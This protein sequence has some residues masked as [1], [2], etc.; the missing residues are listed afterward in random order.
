VLDML[1]P[2]SVI[3]S[4]ALGGGQVNE[5][6][7]SMATPHVAAVAALML[8]AYP[9]LTPAEIEATLKAT[10]APIKDNR[11]GRVTPRVDALSAVT[12][13]I[14]DYVTTSV[15][16]TPSTLS[17]VAGAA[18]TTTLQVNAARNLYSVTARLAFDP[19]IAQVID[20]DPNTPGAQIAVG[21]LWSGR[22]YAVTRNQAD[23]ASGVVE[24]SATLRGSAPPIS[25]TGAIAFIA[26]QGKSAGQSALT[27]QESRLAQPGGSPIPH[28]VK[29]SLIQVQPSPLTGVVSLQG[30]AS[31]AGTTVYLTREL[32]RPTMVITPGLPSAI[33]DVQGRFQ[34]TAP[35]SDYP[36]L[37][38]VRAGYLIG[39]KSAPQGDVGAITLPGGDVIAD[40]VINIYDLTRVA[41]YY[42]GNDP[43]AD[44]NGDGIVNIFDLTLVASN[45]GQSGPVADWR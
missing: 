11:N 21:S 38:I 35:S 7:T 28:Q 9:N 1:A 33:T 44:V 15:G 19:N 23:N 10:G 14:S 16:V 25:G 12:R 22:D 31:H 30:R 20:A 4:T 41:F 18:A 8:Q 43:V 39:Q 40:D 27:L 42:G 5:S 6:G 37:R 3:L 29:N 17:V 36:C 26:W 32:C 24:F 13:V 34:I 45:F 2:G